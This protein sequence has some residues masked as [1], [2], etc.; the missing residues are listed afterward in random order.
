MTKGRFGGH[1]GAPFGSLWGILGFLWGPIEI[2]SSF[3]QI[4]RACRQNQASGN[5]PGNP[6][7]PL[8][9]M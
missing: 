3:F 6:G 1:L 4:H 7:N 5:T 8:E 9:T 2:K